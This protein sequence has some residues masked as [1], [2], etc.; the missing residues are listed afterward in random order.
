MSTT[1]FTINENKFEEYISTKQLNVSNDVNGQFQNNIKDIYKTLK[2]SPITS[3]FQVG[4]CNLYWLWYIYKSK[5]SNIYLIKCYLGKDIHEMYYVDDTIINK[6]FWQF[7][8]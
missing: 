2:T 4:E 6:Y 3:C 7:K 5:N 8:P 1:N